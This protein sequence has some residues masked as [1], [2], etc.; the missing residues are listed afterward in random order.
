MMTKLKLSH[1]EMKAMQVDSA[2][3]LV[4][5]N[6]IKQRLSAMFGAVVMFLW[7]G[8][9][10]PGIMETGPVPFI[11]FLLWSV[12]LVTGIYLLVSPVWRTL[13]LAE[14]RN[15][16]IGG[17]AIGLL[18]FD[19]LPL[20]EFVMYGEIGPFLTIST[21]MGLILYAVYRW[22]ERPSSPNSSQNDLDLFP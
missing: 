5:L 2:A 16:A 17:I 6:A 13:P 22:L 14:R 18:A 15:S 7:L 9:V 1:K 10:E 20:M 12:P 3:L 8:T 11:W 21:M 4:K 19:Y